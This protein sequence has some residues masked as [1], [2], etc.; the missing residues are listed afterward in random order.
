MSY[1]VRYDSCIRHILFTKY[2]LINLSYLLSQSQIGGI[3]DGTR[4]P[5]IYIC[6]WREFAFH[7][8]IRVCVKNSRSVENSANL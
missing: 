8:Y 6:I 2:F 3:F 7:I 4:I 1:R 5:Y